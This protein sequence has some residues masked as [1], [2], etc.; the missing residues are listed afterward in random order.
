MVYK[1]H[2]EIEKADLYLIDEGLTLLKFK[3]KVDFELEDAIEVDEIL[4]NLVEGKP[5]VILIDARNIRSSMSHE[6]R[7]F[8]ANDKNIIDIRKAQAIVVN[9]LHSRLIAKFYMTFNKPPNPIKIF[10][11]YKKA[12]VWIKEKKI[13]CCK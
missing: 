4:I 12:E 11:D 2:I 7:D 6:A 10:N 13:E 5:F 8:F 1:K 3:D 9:N